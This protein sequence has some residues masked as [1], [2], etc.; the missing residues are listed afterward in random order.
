MVAHWVT[1][2]SIG[3]EYVFRQG[4]DARH[5]ADRN[6]HHVGPDAKDGNQA[7]NAQSQE[8]LRSDLAYEVLEVFHT[9]SQPTR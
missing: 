3:L 7:E 5:R 9:I 6:L 1:R 4:Y 2:L 8:D